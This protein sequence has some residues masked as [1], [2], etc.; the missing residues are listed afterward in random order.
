MAQR[1]LVV[2]G[3]VAF[4]TMLKEMLEA[5]GGYQ[6]RVAPGGSDALAILDSEHFDL[7]IVDMDLDAEEMGYRDLIRRVRRALPSMRLVLIPL[8]GQTL[9][10]EA[11]ELNCQGTLSKPFF[12]DDLLPRIKQALS[13]PL[14]VAPLATTPPAAVPPSAARR[15]AAVEPGM[16]IQALLQDLARETRADLAAL[17]SLRGSGRVVAQ[18]GG[19]GRDAAES[20]S[21]LSLA[22]IRAAQRLAHFLGQPDLPFEHNMFESQS[23]R[24]YILSLPGDLALLLATPLEAPLGAVRQNLRRTGRELAGMALT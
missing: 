14:A 3:N 13:T 22:A 16:R 2:D 19:L 11:H 10:P 24:L 12:A 21:G 23:L 4:A 7:T 15:A 18:V 6:V 9:P 5:E 8:M 17:L 20:L 1:I